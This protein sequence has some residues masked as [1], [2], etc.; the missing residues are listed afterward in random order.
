MTKINLKTAASVLALV[1]AALLTQ[2]LSVNAQ[3]AGASTINF[4]DI[5]VTARKQEENLL[6]VPLS[7]TAV[8]AD[9]IKNQG[10]SGIRDIISLTPGLTMSEF[11]AGT[12]NVPVLRG[13]TNLT[14]GA[15][16]E[17]NVAVFYNGVYLQNNNLVDATFLD[18]ERV[19]VVKGPVSALYGRNAYAGVI[20]YVIKRPS[21]ELEASASGIVG[22]RGRL[23]AEASVSGPIAGDMVKARLAGRFDSSSGS[24]QDPV[25]DVRF[26]GYD[27]YAVQGSI[28]ADP[29][30]ALNL[31]ATV[32][33]SNDEFDQPARAFLGSGNCGAAAGAFQTSI[34]GK[35][36][37]FDDDT[38]V[39]SAR[40]AFSLF[41]NKR[42]ALLA[43]LEANLDLGRFNLKSLTSYSETTYN[44]RRDQDGTGVGFAFPLAGT[45][46]GETVNLS[47]YGLGS[48]DENAFS[49]EL[50]ATFD[51]TDQLTVS[52]GGYYNK[53]ESVSTIT[54]AVDPTPVP[55]GRTAVIAFPIG[56]I[57]ANGQPAF[58]NSSDLE[59]KEVSGF[60]SI[61]YEVIPGLTLNA[62]GR[63]S[64]QTKG[65][66]Q[67][68][69][70]TTTPFVDTDGPNGISDSWSFWSYRFSADYQV[71]PDVLLYVSLAEG[72][73]AGG[74][75][76]GAAAVDLQYDPEKNRTYEAGM[77][78]KLFDG[79]AVLDI[80]AFY[81]ELSDLQLQ[82]IA[83]N[84]LSAVIKNAGKAKVPGFEAQISGQV[85]SGVNMSLGVAVADPTFEDGSI[86][87]SGQ[88]RGQ[89]LNIPEC[90]SRVVAIPGSTVLGVDLG[91]LSLPRQS[92]L[93]ASAVI[94][95][96]QPLMDDWD[97][98]FRG[99]YN[100]QSRQY[101]TTPP[102]NNGWIGSRHTLNMRA[103]V[104][105]DRITV[106][107]YVDNALNDGT[108]F[109]YG[110]GLNPSN[111]QSP[112]AIVYGDKR[113]FGLE[114]SV[115]F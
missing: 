88:A 109:N 78:A 114:A 9:T 34:C 69:S 57:D 101:A 72:N 42:D 6:N 38:V 39:R 59:D 98:T 35:I 107:V 89:C 87:N 99:N 102:V 49:Q 43:T 17:L 37:D 47:T 68:E 60:G 56:F 65:Q 115:K 36:P 18:L 26:G 10:V 86:L 51:V 40:P 108:P 96:R 112:I 63:R 24:W 62:E 106:E 16:A 12:L 75:N 50:R 82:F 30:E 92:D 4:G 53:F 5:I 111:F 31:L 7:I 8:T 70:L 2:S 22:T 66:N 91:G 84:G 76:V 33:Y 48:A 103:G 29:A 3:E 20:N 100:F 28:E 15:F 79:R 83:A 21:D 45:T 41:G 23:S 81:A 1:P 52:V 14:A 27:K 32:Y 54:L 67:T 64:K 19:E 80:S 113:S 93:Q 44:Q 71:N 25:S 85:A 13:M 61:A 110:S 104:A 58:T 90:A 46:T 97:W 94:D 95:V 74:F 55:A 11:G 73:K 77:K 105:T